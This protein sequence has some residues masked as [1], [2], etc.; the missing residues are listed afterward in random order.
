M[1][2]L[3]IILVVGFIFF[4][5]YGGGA[6]I[7]DDIFKFDN[8]SKLE[9]EW[10]T[11]TDDNVFYTFYKS[12]RF[13]QIEE[14]IPTAGTWTVA[15]DTLN[16]VFDG[17]SLYYTLDFKKGNEVVVLTATEETIVLEKASDGGLGDLIP[18]EES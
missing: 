16:L 5:V 4:Y 7:I 12:G 1:K 8:E 2:G 3:V 10:E 6:E 13:I 9:G 15:Q 17:E 11:V 14:E 18:F